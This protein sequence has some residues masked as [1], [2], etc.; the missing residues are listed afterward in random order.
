MIYPMNNKKLSKDI[1]KLSRSEPIV[2]KFEKVAPSIQTAEVCEL[3]TKSYAGK[4]GRSTNE[5]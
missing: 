2:R 1:P 5:N 3:E 4:T